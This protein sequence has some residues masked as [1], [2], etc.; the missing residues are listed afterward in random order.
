MEC[1]SK[2]NTPFLAFGEIKYRVNKLEISK[3]KVRIERNIFYYKVSF[4]Q[5]FSRASMALQFLVLVKKRGPII[6]TPVK[7]NFVTPERKTL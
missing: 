2:Q 4:P 1:R 5:L 6:V 7:K 3:M